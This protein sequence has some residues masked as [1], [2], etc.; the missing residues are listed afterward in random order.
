MREQHILEALERM[1]HALEL[2]GRLLD[3]QNRLLEQDHRLLQEI[4]ERPTRHTYQAPVGL[5]FLPD[6]P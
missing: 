3:K 5:R 4:I 6:Q 2:I 1:Q